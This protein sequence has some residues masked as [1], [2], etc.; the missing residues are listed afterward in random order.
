MSTNKQENDLALERFNEEE[1]LRIN[2]ENQGRKHDCDEAKCIV[3]HS[4][5]PIS[6]KPVKAERPKL[7]NRAKELLLKYRGVSL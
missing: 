2:L 1:E 4:I 3:F 6:L 5:D 7:G